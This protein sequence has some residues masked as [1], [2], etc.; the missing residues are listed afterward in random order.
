LKIACEQRGVGLHEYSALP[1]EE[2]RKR[3]D[4]VLICGGAWSTLITEAALSSVQVR[5]VAGEVLSARPTEP[6]QRIVY[7]RE[8]YLVPRRDGRVLIGATM[9]ERGFDKALTSVAR[10]Y[11]LQAACRLLPQVAQWEIED[12]WSGLRPATPDGLPILGNTPLPHVFVATGHFRNGILLTPITAQLMADR[13]LSGVE[14]PFDFSLER[15]EEGVL[16][17]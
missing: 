3:Y 8:V 16:A 10:E 6:L 9:T 12:H 15:F 7:S 13:L 14:L 5:P 11:L 4:T 17:A 2:A 1:L